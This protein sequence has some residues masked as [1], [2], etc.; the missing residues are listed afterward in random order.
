L[1][2]IAFGTSDRTALTQAQQDSAIAGAEAR[3]AQ[4]ETGLPETRW[5]LQANHEVN[6]W[7]F[8]ARASY[9]DNWFDSEDGREYDGKTLVDLEAAYRITERQQ[10]ILGINNVFDETPDE[11][12]G[13]AGGVGNRFSQFSPSDLVDKS[14]GAERRRGFFVLGCSSGVLFTCLT[15]ANEREHLNGRT[16]THDKTLTRGANL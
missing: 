5:N 10:V 12:P 9:Y 4:I 8:L 11:N 2:R 13:A 3:V 7:R 1:E 14:P 15:Q 16:N 6:D